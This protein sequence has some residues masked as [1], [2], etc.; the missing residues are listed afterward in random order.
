MSG[1]QW[2]RGMAGLVA[3]T[4]SSIA[5]CMVIF[6]GVGWS[7]MPQSW[8]DQWAVAGV[9]GVVVG[10]AAAAWLTHEGSSKEKADAD[11]GGDVGSKRVAGSLTVWRSGRATARAGGRS[12]SGVRGAGR[13]AR[14][15]IGRSGDATAIG[16]GSEATSGIDLD[17]EH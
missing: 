11:V 1:L 8:S 17:T 9:F 3:A 7:W 16:P 2:V 15:R 10:G 14:V 6:R 13:D 4:A 12:T 5:L